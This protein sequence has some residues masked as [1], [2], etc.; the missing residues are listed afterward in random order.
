MSEFKSLDSAGISYLWKKIAQA[1]D[2]GGEAVKDA[3]ESLIDSKITMLPYKNF[4]TKTE[5]YYTL[6]VINVGEFQ[7]FT[8]SANSQTGCRVSLPNGGRYLTNT[9]VQRNPNGDEGELSIMITPGGYMTMNIG[10][11]LSS[12]YLRI[13]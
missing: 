11:T 6:P 8:I 1:I 4:G 2:G 3:L 9:F 5:T 7:V 12:F 13:E 10:E